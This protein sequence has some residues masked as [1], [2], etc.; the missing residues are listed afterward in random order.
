[1]KNFK[2]TVAGMGY[3]GLSMAVLLSQHNKVKVVDIIKEKV[4]L[5]K[6]KQSP[7]V[8]KEISDFLENKD[9][10]LEATLD[11]EYAY[12]DAEVVVIA[13]PTSYDS[14]TNH[15]DTSSVEAV[16]ELVLKVNPKALIVVKS[17]IPVGYTKSVREK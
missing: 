4:N 11:G 7:I 16:I 6:N 17:T 5:I 2:I 13:T 9:L 1:M 10:D 14:K 15:F 8:D 12:K 3:V